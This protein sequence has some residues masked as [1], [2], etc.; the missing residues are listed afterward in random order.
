VDDDRGHAIRLYDNP[1]LREKALPIAE[2]SDDV[3]A[4]ADGMVDTMRREKG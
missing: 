4:L 2:V 3:R 1:I